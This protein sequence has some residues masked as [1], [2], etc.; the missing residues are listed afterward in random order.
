MTTQGTLWIIFQAYEIGTMYITRMCE[1]MRQ[2]YYLQ[3]KSEKVA[4]GEWPM[5]SEDFFFFSCF[6]SVSSV[7]ENEKSI[8]ICHRQFQRGTTLWLNESRL[9][10]N[11]NCLLISLRNKSA[12][13]NIYAK[14]YPPR[15]FGK[16]VWYFVNEIEWKWWWAIDDNDAIT[17]VN[18]CFT[19]KS[20]LDWHTSLHAFCF[21]FCDFC[22]TNYVL[23]FLFF[24]T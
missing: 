6:F 18:D 16:F 14:F 5:P 13:R 23:T 8:K 24:L 10:L 20:K 22:L 9:F 17:R 12:V 2:T 4:G 7:G 19:K 11:S 21:W 15:N 1:M 3:K